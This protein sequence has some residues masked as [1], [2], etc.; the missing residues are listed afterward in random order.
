MRLTIEPT[1]F[2]A[3]VNG[4]PA[5]VWRGID[6]QGVAVEVHVRTV[7]PQTHD[8]GV[9]DRYA[10]ELVEVGAKRA[11]PLAIDFSEVR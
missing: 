10:R 11:P 6:D 9:N 7:S 1:P 5:R 2:I 4:E 3:H 8:A